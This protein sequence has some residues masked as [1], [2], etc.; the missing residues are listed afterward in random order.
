LQFA[1]LGRAYAF[2]GARQV[3]IAAYS[4]DP[5]GHPVLGISRIRQPLA[6]FGGNQ[7]KVE[8]DKLP[9]RTENSNSPRAAK[10]N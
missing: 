7:T 6:T 2:A 3:F 1:R 4:P 5:C 9:R 10:F 8:G